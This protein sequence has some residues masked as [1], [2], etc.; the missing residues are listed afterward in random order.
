[1]TA[2]TLTT[3]FIIGTILAI[4]AYDIW[5]WQAYGVEST[6]TQVLAELNIHAKTLAYIVSFAMGT[7][8]GHL[9]LPTSKG[10][11]Q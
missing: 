1:M 7:L 6:I 3:L 8:F 10:G 5:V 4:A 9:F 2:K 11:D